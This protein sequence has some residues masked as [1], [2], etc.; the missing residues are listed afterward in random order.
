MVPLG[1]RPVLWH[2]MRWY[3]HQGHTDFILC[4]GH[5]AD[6][7][8]KYFLEYDETLTNDFVLKPASGTRR[9]RRSGDATTHP[10]DRLSL[11]TDDTSRWSI[12][13][14]DTGTNANIG[15]R[16][17]AVRPYLEED[18]WFLANYADGLTNAS[19]DQMIGHAHKH[20]AASKT[21]ASFLRVRPSQSFHCVEA[22]EGG[23]VTG[24]RTVTDCDVWI[25]AGYFVLHRDVFD[26]LGPGEELVGPAFDRLIEQKRLTSWRH[27]DFF[28][29]MDT[30]KEQQQLSNMV[31]S[32]DAPWMIWQ[33]KKQEDRDAALLRMM[34]QPTPAVR[35]AG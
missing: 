12:T 30:F 16:L 31:Q 23:S 32:G 3:A 18:E 10:R 20:Y 14:V 29:A 33:D 34:K 19:L 1:Y 35:R 8:K 4:L 6:V 25:N 7:I 9:G 11:V 13:F 27:D 26:V 15:Q 24:L 2:I 17:S 21:P 22:N 5:G 28:A